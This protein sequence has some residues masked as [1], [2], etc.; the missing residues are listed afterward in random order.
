[1]NAKH[2][3]AVAVLAAL[4]GGAFAQ[5]VPPPAAPDGKGQVILS[6]EE[7]L[8]ITGYDPARR[9]SQAISI[10]WSEVESLLGV[11]IENVGE[12]AV[13]DLPWAEFKALLEWS[14]TRKAGKPVAPPPTDYI[15]AAGQYAGTLSD[16]AAEFTLKLSA[17]VLRKDA[18][19]SIPVLPSDVAIREATLPEGV[20]LNVVDNTYQLLTDKTGPI[21]ASIKFTVA[22]QKSAGVNTAS[23]Q[24]MA[25]GSAILDLTL[26]RTDVEVKVPASQ[27]LAVTP[28]DGK[29]HVA[30]ALAANVPVTV[31]WERAL[32]K[33][34]P[35]PT[36]MYA[37]TRTLVAV[38]EGLLVCQ[39]AVNFNILHSPVREVKLAVPE[40][41]SVLTVTGGS[42]QD[43]R[44]KDGELTVALRSETIGSL[45]LGI[46][47]E[48]PAKAGQDQTVEAPVIRALG[49]ER[50]RGFIAVVAVTNVEIGAGN[51][52]GA[53][54][55]DVRQLPPD[56]LAMTN[57]PILLGFRYV[58]AA[59]EEVGKLAVPLVVRRHKEV[60]VLVTLVD[61]G[62]FTG[63]QLSDGRR[64]TKALYSVRNNRNQF[65]RL[66][67]PAGAE[68]WSVSVGGNAVTPAK[69]EAQDGTILIP[70]IRSAA[71]S[72]QDLE[73]FPVEIVYVELFNPKDPS[74]AAPAAGTLRVDIPSL[75]V[76]V[77]HA[78]YSYYAPAEGN[79]TVSAGLFARRP[80]FAGPLQV[81]GE[82]TPLSTSSGGRVTAVPAQQAPQQMEKQVQARLEAEALKAGATP[83]R[84]EL[85]V[86][87]KLFKL[88]KILALPGDDL[89]FQVSYSGWKVAR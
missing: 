2:I 19:V 40:G 36:K 64:I 57:Q 32:P 83:I 63:M 51:V 27:S 10:P 52:A 5:P 7:F 33:V 58:S 16:E 81:V 53:T 69:D 62:T 71:T 68:I 23:F 67:M 35:A 89:W 1:M 41:A 70:L 54:A 25:P 73:A 80:G 11:K 39:E 74:Q 79:Y 47:F 49:V 24:R 28:G 9:G 66:K 82:F 48:R 21:E 61:S 75:D 86:N 38:A 87:G 76:P 55:I 30:A 84:V 46:S 56:I 18:W 6:W 44:T 45:N 60:G 37:E 50:E 8:K 31:T 17:N 15:L 43:W 34:P 85:P 14:V 77:M 22:V 59:G 78:M 26:D 13:V 3:A 29:T 12:G 88:E 72:V 20:Y 65:L 4:V 42:V